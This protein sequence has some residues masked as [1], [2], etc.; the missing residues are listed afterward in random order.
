MHGLQDFIPQVASPD[1][2]AA[3]ALVFPFVDRDLLVVVD[4]P[5]AGRDGWHRQGGWRRRD[6]GSPDGDGSGVR[7]LFHDE[8]EAM[9]RDGRLSIKR[10]QFLGTLRGRQAYSLEL[11]P[12]SEAPAGLCLHNLRRLVPMLAREHFW[13][14]ARAVQIVAWDRDH[15]FCGRCGGPTE[16]H[17]DERSRRCVACSLAVY[18]RISPAVIV[19]VERGD[20]ILL[21]RSPHFVPG[22]Y[23]T[24]AGFVEPGETLESTVL[25]EIHEEVGVTVE[26]IRYF[27]SQPWPFP[28]SLMIGFRADYAAGDIV[29]DGVE[30]EAADWFR[31]ETL[32]KLPF[33]LSIARALIEAFLAENR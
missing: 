2:W 16:L 13:L 21:A 11:E 32:P 3:D 27:G 17:G 20:E 5:G 30:I 28:N 19:L 25:R 12:I 24:L 26:N 6:L 4:D 15:Q 7:V 1:R 23:S 22:V 29:V 9:R 33:K 14:A 10:R 31:R 8:V 18:P